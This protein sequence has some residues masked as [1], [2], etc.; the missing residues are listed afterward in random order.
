MEVMLVV[1][2]RGQHVHV[3]S[4][5]EKTA[6]KR[7][8]MKV[9]VL[10]NSLLLWRAEDLWRWNITNWEMAWKCKQSPALWEM[11]LSL[12]VERK[13]GV[14]EPS[15]AD[16]RVEMNRCSNWETSMRC[17]EIMGTLIMEMRM[18]R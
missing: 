15:E 18:G 1:R 13:L 16:A 6:R 10:E 2:T 12:G 4:A 5:N 7:N 17:S 14:V 8:A 11:S 9:L 3:G